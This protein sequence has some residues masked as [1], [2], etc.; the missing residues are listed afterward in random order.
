MLASLTKN[1]NYWALS[2]MHLKF[3]QVGL[4]NVKFKPLGDFDL[5][6]SFKNHCLRQVVSGQ[7]FSTGWLQSQYIEPVCSTPLL[8]TPH[9]T[10]SKH[11]LLNK[12]DYRKMYYTSL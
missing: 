9:P 1:A 3:L 12:T 11:R 5:P 6:E 8:L 4:S 10:P 2:H 7:D